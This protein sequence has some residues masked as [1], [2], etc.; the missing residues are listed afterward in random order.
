MMNYF[1]GFDALNDKDYNDLI[2]EMEMN[3]LQDE[4]AAKNA[5]DYFENELEKNGEGR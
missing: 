3:N 4:L 1:N 5:A 2:E